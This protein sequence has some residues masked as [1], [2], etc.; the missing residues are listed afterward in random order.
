LQRDKKSATTAFFA[1]ASIE[2]ASVLRGSVDAND[3]SARR[4]AGERRE[5]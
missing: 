1:A 5:V 4:A 2:T 3:G